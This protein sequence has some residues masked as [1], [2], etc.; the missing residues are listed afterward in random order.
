M[1]ELHKILPP[2]GGLN[3]RQRCAEGLGFAPY[4]HSGPTVIADHILHFVQGKIIGKLHVFETL[5][6]SLA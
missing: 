3:K 1:F 6:R 5:L 4:S 2:E